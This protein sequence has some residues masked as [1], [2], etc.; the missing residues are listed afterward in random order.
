[1]RYSNK[2]SISFIKAALIVVLVAAIGFLVWRTNRANTSVADMLTTKP[3]VQGQEEAVPKDHDVASLGDQ[4]DTVA[5]INNYEYFSVKLPEGWEFVSVSGEIGSGSGVVYE[6][7]DGSNIIQVQ[8]EPAGRG[9][10]ADVFW[11]YEE[12]PEDRSVSVVNAA[13]TLCTPDDGYCA[14][15]GSL[16]V[17]VKHQ[18]D[19]TL[20]FNGYFTNFYY[21]SPDKEAFSEAEAITFQNF[22]ES[23]QFTTD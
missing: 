9:I 16:L 13:N 4:K 1:M 10:A 15:D 23:I 5:S 7:T 6:Y 21:E 20:S 11:R 18:D 12:N 19:S 22:I 8:I 14:R 2:G 17:F 3:L